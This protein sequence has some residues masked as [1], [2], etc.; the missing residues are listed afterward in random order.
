M[1]VRNIT[2]NIAALGDRCDGRSLDRSEK[3]YFL[4]WLFVLLWNKHIYSL[5]NLNALLLKEKLII[6]FCNININSILLLILISI[7]ILLLILSIR[8]INERIISL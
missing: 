8:N 5:P 4:L 1:S 7:P 6:N 2:P 3:F